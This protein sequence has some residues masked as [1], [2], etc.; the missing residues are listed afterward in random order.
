MH[1]VDGTTPVP[2]DCGPLTAPEGGSVEI[3]ATTVGGQATFACDE[4]GY[5]ST[6]ENI[7][8]VCEENGQWS[9]GV[10]GCSLVD[11]GDPESIAF[12]SVAVESTLYGSVVEYRCI[13]GYSLTG[14]EDGFEPAKPLAN[15]QASYPNASQTQYVAMG[16]A[17]AMRSAMAAPMQVTTIRRLVI[18]SATSAVMVMHLI[19]VTVFEMGPK[20][21]T[22]EIPPSPT[23]V[24]IPA[25]PHPV[26]TALFGMRKAV[27]KSATMRMRVTPTRA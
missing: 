7:V 15:G 16:F 20:R 17:R 21:A 22:T 6:E 10:P 4:E 12:A 27:P 13:D 2:V 18:R 3:T 9:G 8:L 23:P 5:Q 19:V 25:F 11:C 1:R 26:V 14:V 24:L